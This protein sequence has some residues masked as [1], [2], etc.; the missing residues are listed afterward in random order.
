MSGEEEKKEAKK[1]KKRLT[2]AELEALLIENFTSLQK[3]L[4]NLSIKFEQLS[5]QISKLLQLFEI[6]AKDFVEKH[7]SQDKEL[8]EKIDKL[9]EQNKVIA[10]GLTTLMEEKLRE[11]YGVSSGIG[12]AGH[13]SDRMLPT[14]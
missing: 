7:Q 12:R 14:V 1:K 5:E 3:V 13:S 6:A 8:A 11:S 9:L 10:R 4:T 2:K